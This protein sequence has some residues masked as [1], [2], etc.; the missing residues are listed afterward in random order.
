MGEDLMDRRNLKVPFMSTF[1]SE[2]NINLFQLLMLLILFVR[3]QRSDPA[4]FLDALHVACP[5]II[6]LLFPPWFM[7]LFAHVAV[8]SHQNKNLEQKAISYTRREETCYASSIQSNPLVTE[9]HLH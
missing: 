4:F 1:Y 8:Q 2:G 3:E 5:F 9:V 7:C 6:Q